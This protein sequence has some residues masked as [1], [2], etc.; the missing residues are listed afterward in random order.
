MPVSV[1][2]TENGN[3]RGD[4]DMEGFDVAEEELID[5]YVRG[6][7]SLAD[8]TLLE[9]GLRSSPQ[10]VE[11]LHF[12]RLL[13]DAADRAA[14]DE[15]A[16]P[17][18]QAVPSPAAWRPFGLKWGRLAFNLAFATCALIIFIGAASLLGGWLR[19]RRESRQL[20]D[21]RAALERQKLELQKSAAE[22]RLATDQMTAELKDKQTKLEADQQRIDELTQ[23][24]NQKPVASSATTATI[25]LLPTSRSS[26]EKEISLAAGISKIR[27][28]LAVSSIDYPAFVAEVR[29]SQQ[30]EIAHPKVGAPR[31]GKP[32]IITILSKLLPSGAYSLQLSGVLTDGTHEPVGNYSFRI[33]RR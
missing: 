27:L 18:E 23:A 20:A 28:Q 11:R 7:L 8:R 17:R 16:L 6:E 12:A 5:A 15:L 13:A 30:Q 25:F 9:K 2:R 19:I 14:V 1:N 24:L 32:V 33:I 10:L 29:N 26:P 4:Q 3:P 21:Q 31:A 22:Q